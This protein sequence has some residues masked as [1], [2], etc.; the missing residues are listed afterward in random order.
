[1]KTD[2]HHL[3]TLEDWFTSEFEK[4][5]NDLDLRSTMGM[6]SLRAYGCTIGEFLGGNPALGT[7]NPER[8]SLL[9][10]FVW[11]R[12]NN[13]TEPDGIRIFVKHEPHKSSKL[14]EGRHRL[15]SAVSLVDAMTDRIMF[16]W[17]QRA[18][19]DSLGTHPM[20]LGWSPIG[21]GARWITELFRGKS[22][23]GLDMT[24]WDWTVPGW[25]L[26]AM[27]DIL[28]ELAIGASDSWISWVDARW[29]ALFRD[30]EFVFGDGQTIR[31]PGWGVMK[32]GC[33]LTIL[34]NSMGQLVR[35]YLVLDRLGIS[36]S[37]TFVVLGDDETI[38]DFP[39]FREYERETRALGFLLKDSELSSGD[40]HFAGFQFGQKIVPAYGDKHVF[41]MTHTPRDR[42]PDVLAAYQLLYAD[43][44]DWFLWIRM[45][46]ARLSPASVRPRWDLQCILRGTTA[47]ISRR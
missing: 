19:I 15:I 22:T 16:G 21:G 6:T 7:A 9:R 39:R 38:E 30:A 28:K 45:E 12:L 4:A 2:V 42:L 36:L 8:V 11:N 3:S 26:L 40:V 34:L 29:E 10:E 32:S 1:M 20:A 25:L 33:Y 41:V 5:L 35:H 27:K 13:P 37:P 43:V 31:Q 46:L 18:A 44:D 47:G 23:R 14:Q 24:A 17:V